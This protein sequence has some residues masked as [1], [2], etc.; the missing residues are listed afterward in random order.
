MKW[1]MAHLRIGETAHCSSRHFADDMA[2]V[3][4]Y[5]NDMSAKLFSS[6]GLFAAGLLLI[7]LVTGLGWAWSRGAGEA[8]ENIQIATDHPIRVEHG[9]A[10]GSTDFVSVESGSPRA[11]L[12][13]SFY[14]FG[15]IT[16]KAVV[17]R[18]FLVINRGKAPLIIY[19]A[20]TTCGCTT[21][22]LTASRVPPGQAARATIIFNAGYHNVTGQTVRRGLILE[23]NDPDHPEVEIWV[24]AEILK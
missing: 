6:K 20:Y 16:S 18:D 11:E 3:C 4:A 10:D 1:E 22:E 13:A 9:Q 24:Q 12:P 5:P 8:A 21:A 15:A 19:Q 23:T 7:V 14:D 2:P 17:K